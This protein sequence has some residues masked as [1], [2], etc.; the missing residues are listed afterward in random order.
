MS[1]RRRTDSLIS[2]CD[3][4][5]SPD[6]SVFRTSWD[7]SFTPSAVN[8]PGLQVPV[9]EGAGPAAL[10]AASFRVPLRPPARRS[11]SGSMRCT[12]CLDL[13]HVFGRRGLGRFPRGHGPSCCPVWNI[14][15]S[16]HVAVP[17]R[18]RRARVAGCPV[19]DAGLST[20]CCCP[21][22]AP[23]RPWF[24]VLMAGGR[25]AWWPVWRTRKLQPRGGT[26]ARSVFKQL[27]R[28]Q[29]QTFVLP[30]AGLFTGC[31]RM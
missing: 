26:F 10:A 16:A 28:E 1:P 19:W 22:R 4:L 3:L 23:R 12:R 29:T 30:T 27:S 8:R 5:C 7:V 2:F 21:V 14:S 20:P 9:R 31:R 6:S 11:A 17:C 25:R 13:G 18:P 15:L 24:T